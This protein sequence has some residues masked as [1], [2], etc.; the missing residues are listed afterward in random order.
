MI[1]IVKDYGQCPGFSIDIF[2]QLRKREKK[3]LCLVYL[4]RKSV[5]RLKSWF[6]DCWFYDDDA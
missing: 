2:R 6:L 4:V 3:E 1:G 5:A